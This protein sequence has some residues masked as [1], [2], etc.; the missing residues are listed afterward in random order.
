MGGNLEISKQK[1]CNATQ[2]EE[3]AAETGFIVAFI[4]LFVVQHR[5]LARDEE[6]QAPARFVDVSVH[7]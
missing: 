5:K 3:R 1:T 2:R 7:A 6:P 4:Y